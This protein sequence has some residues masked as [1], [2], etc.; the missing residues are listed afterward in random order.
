MIDKLE[1]CLRDVPIIAILRGVPPDH[2]VEIGNT[3]VAAGIRVIEVPLNSPNALS[4]IKLLSSALGSK[5]VTGA[6]TFLD[7]RDIQR[8]KE[9]GG[10]ILV[11]PNT[12]SRLIKATLK[13]GLVPLP[14][15][16]TATEAITACQAGATYLKLFPASSYGVDHVGAI[17]AVLPL[18]IRIIPVGGVG[19]ENARSWLRA[20]VDGLG[21]GTDIYRPN[22]TVDQVRRNAE[23]LLNAIA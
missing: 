14:G 20:G 3:L 12:D 5:C 16:S 9:A 6:G 18:D 1:S 22:D 17:R 19:T 23:K 7:G 21:V 13:A 4:S 8:V 10:Q 15:F 2:V 11:S